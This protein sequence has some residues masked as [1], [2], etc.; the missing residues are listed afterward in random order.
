MEI[1]IV[2]PAPNEI[3]PDYLHQLGGTYGS[4]PTFLYLNTG[5]PKLPNATVRLSAGDYPWK[6]SSEAPYCVCWPIPVVVA[7][8]AFVE[9]V[10]SL[11]PL[12]AAVAAGLHIDTSNAPAIDQQRGDEFDVPTGADLGVQFLSP[13]AQR[14]R[15]QI[16]DTLA[17]L[18][19]WARIEV[20]D[21]TLTEA[22]DQELLERISPEASVY[23]DLN[24]LA[25]TIRTTAAP[26]APGNYVVIPRLLDHL[27]GL[28]HRVRERE[29]DTLEVVART[30]RTA[31]EDRDRR[32]CRAAGWTDVPRDPSGATVNSHRA[33]GARVNLSG[34]GVAKI[35]AR[36]RTEESGAAPDVSDLLNPDLE[37]VGDEL[38]GLHLD[39]STPEQR[40]R[41]NSCEHPGALVVA[42]PDAE[43]AEDGV[44][45]GTG[46]HVSNEELG[47]N[48]AGMR[49]D[50]AIGVC[51]A[52]SAP[53]V[54]FRMWQG[55][56]TWNTDWT[57]LHRAGDPD[58]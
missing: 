20:Q 25:K 50:S 57:L 10:L 1:D 31:T 23:P 27:R 49:V 53:V 21:V 55:G 6:S 54:T 24:E 33:L 36:V 45:R 38:E 3:P 52:C 13:Q 17:T 44:S 43:R 12:F 7:D 15:E 11:E 14:A 58:Y 37:H 30:A 4:D 40:Y 47:R 48:L 18:E 35:I 19:D 5:F 9:L 56:A 16:T 46:L 22:Q 8:A 42:G 2:V 32:L 29:L 34:R 51:G 41:W 39:R 28:Q 26:S